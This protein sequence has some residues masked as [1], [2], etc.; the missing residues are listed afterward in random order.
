MNIDLNNNNLIIKFKQSDKQYIIPIDK[1]NKYHDCY[2]LKH[3]HF[4]NTFECELDICNY[5]DFHIIFQYIMTDDMNIFDYAFNQQLLDYFGIIPNNKYIE[6]KRLF[7]L[8]Y[9]IINDFINNKSKFLIMDSVDDYFIYKD[10]FK[11]YK[12]I[13]PFQYMIQKTLDNVKIKRDILFCGNGQLCDFSNIDKLSKNNVQKK[14]NIVTQKSFPSILPFLWLFNHKNQLEEK[15]LN[16]NEQIPNEQFPNEQFT[17]EIMYIKNC[18]DLIFVREFK[19]YKNFYGYKSM[20]WLNGIDPK[21]YLKNYN[22]KN[23]YEYDLSNIQMS[24]NDFYIRYN[25]Y[26]LH[27]PLIKERVIFTFDDDSFIKRNIKVYL[28]FINMKLSED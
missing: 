23:M 1:L 9:K 28:G 13:I 5:E 15:D 7:D 10:I 17:N 14:Q 20:H 21:L 25:L 16:T 8:K 19:K 3:I 27:K 26:S 12:H 2:F 18:I 6:I 22:R 4:S 11:E 24:F